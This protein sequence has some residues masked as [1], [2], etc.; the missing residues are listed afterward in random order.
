MSLL[1][2]VRQAKRPSVSEFL[3]ALLYE[4][5]YKSTQA[6]E[7]HKI[8]RPTTSNKPTHGPKP[9]ATPSQP[10]FG[11]ALTRTALNRLIV[12]PAEK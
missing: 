10:D 8:D 11:C 6:P 5:Q 7:T 12:V 9:K 4:L 2:K 3:H 1:Q